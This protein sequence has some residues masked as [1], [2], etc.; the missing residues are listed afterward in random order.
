MARVISADFLTGSR[1]GAPG[2]TEV[3]VTAAEDLA[4][5]T[6]SE[7]LAQRL[8]LVDSAGA[9][10]PGPRAVTE[11]DAV[12]ESLASPVLRDAPGFVGRGFTSGGA[13]EFI[14]PNLEI[15]QLS[16]ATIRIVQ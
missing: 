12:T 13:R 16:N 10:I 3:W 8:T 11:F 15:N 6:T 7:G 4:G 9:L 5:I 2:A 1:L 14:L